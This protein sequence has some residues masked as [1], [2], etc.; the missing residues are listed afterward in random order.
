MPRVVEAWL[1]SER[2]TP[3]DGS[4]AWEATN[5]VL[6]LDPPLPDDP[7]EIRED[8]AALE[9]SLASTGWVRPGE[10]ER[11]WVYAPHDGRATHHGVRIYP[12]DAD[13]QA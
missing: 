1:E 9:R 7:T 2:L 4:P 8:I 11:A 12:R 3:T 6:V 13:G 10:S 5:I